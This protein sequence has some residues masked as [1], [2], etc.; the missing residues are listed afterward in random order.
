LAG[1]FDEGVEGQD[2]GGDIRVD[3]GAGEQTIGYEGEC[4]VQVIGPADGYISG[5]KWNSSTGG[6]YQV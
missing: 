3:T 6:T 4:H 1:E 2:M 5:Q